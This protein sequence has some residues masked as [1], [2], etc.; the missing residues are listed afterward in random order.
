M[1]STDVFNQSRV[2]VKAAG[3]GPLNPVHAIGKF[4]TNAIIKPVGGT[5][6]DFLIGRKALTGPLAGTRLRVRGNPGDLKSW[7]QLSPERYAKVKSDPVLSK[8][9]STATV[10]G[11]VVNVLRKRSVGGIAGAAHR[12]PFI[13][14][15]LLGGGWYLNKA[16]QRDPYVE[17]MLQL[18]QAAQQQ[19]A[20]QPM[21][22]I[23]GTF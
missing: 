20:Y 3:L 12:H 21:S 15:G 10:D 14:S 8:L 2:L 9:L 22:P 6:Q 5:L 1:N 23:A 11:K 19:Q 7:V 4:I 16:R 18:Q 13:T 17:Q